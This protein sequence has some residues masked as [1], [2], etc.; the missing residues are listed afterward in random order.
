MYNVGIIILTRFPAT[1]LKPTPIPAFLLAEIKIG[2]SA[3]II[4]GDN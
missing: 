2:M 1:R 4:T 3:S